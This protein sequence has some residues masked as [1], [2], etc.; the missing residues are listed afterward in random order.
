MAQN[1][2]KWLQNIPNCHKI[3]QIVTKYTKS[4]QNTSTKW[5]QNIPD[6]SKIVQIATEYTQ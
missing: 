6:E 4:L 3:Y 5:Q 2:Q 1:I